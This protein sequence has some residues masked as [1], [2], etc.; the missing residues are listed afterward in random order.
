MTQPSSQ[1][2]SPSQIVSVLVSLAL[3]VLSLWAISE[4]FEAYPPAEILKSLMQIQGKSLGFATGL[5][6]ANYLL[7]TGYDVLAIRAIG[8]SLGYSKTALVSVISYAI[9]NSLG[10]A[11]LSGSVIRYRFY[12]RWQFSAVEITQIIAFANL[13]FWLGL[14]ALGGILFLVE[15][16]AIPTL[17]QL[18]FKSVHPLGVIFLAVVLVYLLWN[19]IGQRR[20]LRIGGW[21]LPHLPWPLASAQLVNA[22]GDWALAAATLY[23]LLPAAPKLT[24]PAFFAI[25]LLAQL[26]GVI[27]NVPGGLGVFETVML[28]LLSPTIAA[29]TLLSALLAY[30]VV[31]Y[32]FPLCLGIL[33]L[34]L[35]ELKRW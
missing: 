1:R 32:I 30:R 3:L 10:F 11:L 14:L 17:L 8:R 12:T 15:P 25:F 18:P 2:L 29:P 27:S 13:S 31:Y 33:L 19:A 9:S 5:T 21:V 22:G 7:L 16:L 26:A 35:S 6:I 34:G 24:F 20:S 4:E 23:V 28:L